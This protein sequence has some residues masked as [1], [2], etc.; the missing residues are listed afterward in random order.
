MTPS[1]WERVAGFGPA[2]GWD[3]RSGRASEYVPTAGDARGGGFL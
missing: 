3:R 1:F 2:G